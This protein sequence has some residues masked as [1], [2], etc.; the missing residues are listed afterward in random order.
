[1]E[2]GFDGDVCQCRS[3][4]WKVIWVTLE[5]VL[6]LGE[7]TIFRGNGISY[8]QLALKLFRKRLIMIIYIVYA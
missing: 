1:M 4:D 2:C 7:H 5:S 8:L 6:V 3:P